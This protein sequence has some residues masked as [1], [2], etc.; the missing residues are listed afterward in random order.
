[1][2]PT[3]PA[4][5]APA[6]TTTEGRTL[7]TTRANTQIVG[8]V[9]AYLRG[10]GEYRSSVTTSYPYPLIESYDAGRDRA[11]ALTFRRYDDCA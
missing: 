8:R 9:C 5:N 6:D 2:S 7:R 3:T 4:T 1:M 10:V 11:H